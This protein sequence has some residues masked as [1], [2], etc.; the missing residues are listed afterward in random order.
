[1]G[2]QRVGHDWATEWQQLVG[3][4][5][6]DSSP[7]GISPAG[8]LDLRYL[9]AEFLEK[10]KLKYL[11]SQSSEFLKPHATTFCWWEQ[12]TG[13]PRFKEG[14]N[15]R[16]CLWEWEEWQAWAKMQRI[17]GGRVHRRSALWPPQYIS[18]PFTYQTP[19][20]SPSKPLPSLLELLQQ[21]PLSRPALEYS[22]HSCQDDLVKT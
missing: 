2:L 12:I 16:P 3:G 7:R 10:K 15:K 5:A 8:W 19:R 18:F 20:F 6:A 9:E 17:E 13:Q 4:L 1:M 22:P 21:P 14:G 11:L